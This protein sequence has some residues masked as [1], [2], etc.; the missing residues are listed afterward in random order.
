MNSSKPTIVVNRNTPFVVETFSPSFHVI[1]LDSSEVTRK[2]V[3][4]ADALVVRSETKVDRDLLEGSSVRFVGTVTI[5]TDHVDGEYLRSKGISFVSAPGSN[6][7]SVAE[8]IAAALLCWSRR[9]KLSL[10]TKTLGI[11]G[12]GNVGSKVEKVA[13]ALGMNYLLNDPPLARAT[14]SPA[15]RPLEELMDADFITL[16]VPL[17]KEDPDRTF[18]LFDKTMFEKTKHGSVLINTS[19]GAVV[20]S[21]ALSDTLASGHLSAAILDVWENE[22]NINID[23]LDKVLLGTPHIAGYSLD[24]KLN[25]LKQVY[26]AATQYFGL[27][28][29]WQSE[30]TSIPSDSAQI[31]IPR[32]LS[33]AEDILNLAIRQA[34]D[35]ELDDFLLREAA[36]LRI[37]ERG[38]YFMK[39]R[40]EYRVRR[41]FL[42]RVVEL[43]PHQGLADEVLRGLGF[44]T[45][46]RQEAEYIK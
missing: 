27:P 17:T 24:G 46:V 42:N 39:L 20:D 8:Y 38:K 3:R 1:S 16:H 32:G 13:Q 23:L 43:S 35:I 2:A 4:N 7:N 36:A 5:G 18:H 28:A 26:D 30:F 31:K 11:V 21:K 12:V 34:Y 6:A 22:P 19:R 25:A 33:N 10:K 41:E 15:Y 44:K 9:T 37:P 40:A 14:G 29:H 45:L